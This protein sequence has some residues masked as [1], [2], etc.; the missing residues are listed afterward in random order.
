MP[1][2]SEPVTTSRNDLANLSALTTTLIGNIRS[3]N[4]NWEKAKSY[5]AA[6]E[7]RTRITGLE[8]SDRANLVLEILEK[9]EVRLDAALD[10][11]ECI[12][13]LIDHERFGSLAGLINTGCINVF[14]ENAAFLKKLRK[15]SGYE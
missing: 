12:N 11:F 13:D 15:E 7:L 6:S 14:N 9:V 5:A 10:P 4:P 2:N 3:E 1:N 8:F